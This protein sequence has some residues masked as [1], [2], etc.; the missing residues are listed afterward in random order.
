MNIEILDFY[1]VEY[2]EQ[3]GI[4]S[5]TIK[6]KLTDFG[7]L[8]LGIYV[9]K[10][11]D[12]WFFSLPGR[13]GI[14]SE[15]EEVHYPAISFEDR[16]KQKELISA[17]REKGREFIEQKIADV[18]NPIILPQQTKQSVEDSKVLDAKNKASE[19]KET[20]SKPESSKPLAF[21][22]NSKPVNQSKFVEVP[23]SPKKIRTA[24][25]IQRY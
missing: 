1:P 9:S 18:E 21:S 22:T 14:N 15:G 17:I 2:K 23:L 19:V 13:R 5:G 24:K 16:E 11:K 8:I 6:A 20:V 10:N 4:L 7:I 12:R 3:K 25:P